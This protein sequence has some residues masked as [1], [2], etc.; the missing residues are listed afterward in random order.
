ML[1]VWFSR[2]QDRGM[3]LRANGL[4]QNHHISLSNPLAICIQT[5]SKGELAQFTFNVNLFNVNSMWTRLIRINAHLMCIIFVMWMGLYI[6]TYHV[7]CVTV[8][9]IWWFG[10][11]HKDHQIKH[12]PFINQFILLAWVSFHTVLKTTTIKSYK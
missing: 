9:L 5:T 10:E 12:M 3:G 2:T 4:G 7:V 8:I 1:P 6:S 11:S